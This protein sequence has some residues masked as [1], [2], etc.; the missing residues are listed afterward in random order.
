M[1]APSTKTRGRLFLSPFLKSLAAR[2][3]SRPDPLRSGALGCVY[4]HFLFPLNLD[5]PE[6][7]AR[8]ASGIGLPSAAS[9]QARTAFRAEH[10][11]LL[12]RPL[13]DFLIHKHFQEQEHPGQVHFDS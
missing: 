4:L 11:P 2:T 6:P 5:P 12:R 1:E 13:G 9:A 8:A 3:L 10:P 7:P